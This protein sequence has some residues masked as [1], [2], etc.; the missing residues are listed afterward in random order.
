MKIKTLKN[1]YFTFRFEY[2]SLCSARALCSHFR[3][4]L[5]NADSLRLLSYSLVEAVV[6][7]YFTSFCWLQF[8][9][10]FFPLPS[11]RPP[12]CCVQ[13]LL[14]FALPLAFVANAVHL[15]LRRLALA[16]VLSSR[17]VSFWPADCCI[18]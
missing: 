4:A 14:C 11:S 8:L 1:V 13:L 15:L 2:Y 16:S 18:S 5:E 6:C 9:S 10:N 7:R 3:T 12:L 17:V